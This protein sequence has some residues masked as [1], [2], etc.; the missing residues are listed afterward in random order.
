MS[1]FTIQG[2]KQA[3]KSIQ[4]G[5]FVLNS[6]EKKSSFRL[7]ETS[8]AY[9]FEKRTRPEAFTKKREVLPAISF[10]FVRYQNKIIPLNRKLNLTKHPHW[11]YFVGVGNI[12]QEIDDGK[13]SRIAIPFTL[14]EK[15]QNCTHNG[16]LS[17]LVDTE[18]RTSQFYYQIS[19]ETC[20]YFKIDMWGKGRV[21]YQLT[22]LG[23]INL[24]VEYYK[25][26][27]T[28]Q[29]PKQPIINLQK[30]EELI[31]LE[32]IS[33][34]DKIKPI[35]MSAY[36]VLYNGIHYVSRC[37]TR[38]GEYPFCD[39]LILPSYS[40]AKS[41]FAGIGLF[42]LVKTYPTIFEEKVSDWV[43]ECQGDTWRNVTFAHLLNMTT[44]NYQYI[45]HSVD[46]SAEH[47]QQ[48]FKATSHHEKITYSCQQFS[49]NS[50]P[51]KVFTYHSSDTYILGS[52]LNNFILAQQKFK[53]TNQSNTV[54]EQVFIKKLWPHLLLSQVAY[55][56]LK[57]VGNYQQAF[58]GYGMFFTQ[59]D[60]AKLINF[61]I[62]E[63]NRKG[64]LLNES[65]LKSALQHFPSEKDM[66]TQYQTIHYLDGF[67]RQN[68]TKLLSC[69]K[70]TWLPFMSGYGGIAIVFAKPNLQY[71]YFSDSDQHNWLSTI[72][73][74]NKIIPLCRS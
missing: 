25:K 52:A 20:L 64:E 41:I 70:E 72:K 1:A 26:T 3:L 56:T 21:D 37:Q 15:N 9:Q 23:D 14:V 12:W 22:K 38:N 73:E 66:A 63:Q 74:L 29:I 53:E 44:G 34:A 40:T 49:R 47:S 11:D 5:R 10:D 4:Q 42:Y 58:T 50:T 46:E 62:N 57:T 69:E 35:D 27:L 39:Q 32:K 59:E 24:S 55:S 54:F 51:G 31:Q 30:K 68:I 60:I 71:Y 36:G 19:S 48:F 2:E 61:L 43:E 16:A 65:H 28:S 17:F 7:T 13:F 6:N 18:G 45:G 67:W 33:L 8:A